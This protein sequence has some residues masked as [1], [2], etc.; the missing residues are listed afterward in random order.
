MPQE[1]EKIIKQT[2]QI[3]SNAKEKPS[4]STLRSGTL[5]LTDKR[6]LYVKSKLGITIYE[7]MEDLE[8]DLRKKGSFQIPL[9]TIREIQSDRHRL[10]QYFNVNYETD[11]GLK[12]QSFWSE[13]NIDMTVWVEAIYEEL[14][15]IKKTERPVEAGKRRERI[16]VIVDQSHEQDTT[17]SAKIVEAVNGMCNRLE[18][19]EP[20]A[21]KG[22]PKDELLVANQHLLPETALLIS[23][24]TKKGDKFSAKEHDLIEKYVKN[25]G[26]FLITSY[27][28]WEPPN[29][30]LEPFGVKIGETA[31]KDEFHHEGKHNDHI[32]VEDLISHPINEGVETISF[33][34]YG[35]YPLEIDYPEAITLAFSSKDAEPPK[36]PVAALIPYGE[37][38]VIVIGQAR[39]F[40]DK[41]I[42]NFDNEK[43]FENILSYMFKEEQKIITEEKP[44]LIPHEP[45]EPIMNYCRNCG[46]KLEAEDVFCGK[47]G[48]RVK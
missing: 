16:F 6:L 10:V 25:G 22:R 19:E 1:D 29:S 36:A 21:L 33:G 20:I 5:V 38:R 26:R 35:C 11:S 18:L 2:T 23:L 14:K 40:Q 4:L 12:F 41:I 9:S 48:E 24:A 47:C 34:D 31:I 8:E 7:K 3:K 13:Q 43:W 44:P 42:D 17:S 46:A 28:P 27:P 37:G 45:P 15:R 30:I 39:L 32:I